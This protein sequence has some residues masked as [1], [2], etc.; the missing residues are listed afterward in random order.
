MIHNF[1]LGSQPRGIPLIFT[2]IAFQFQPIEAPYIV[3]EYFSLFL[4]F[5]L[6]FFHSTFMLSFSFS[7]ICY[8]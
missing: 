4:P 7:E 6:S 5:Y 1:C 2:W 3:F 8:I